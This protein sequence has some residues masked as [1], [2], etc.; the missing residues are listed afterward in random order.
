MY[1]TRASPE[2][3]AINSGR[4]FTTF[5]CALDWYTGGRCMW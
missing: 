4:F 2:E 5:N 1:C 3:P